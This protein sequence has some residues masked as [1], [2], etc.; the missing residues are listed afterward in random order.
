MAVAST[1]PNF[2]GERTTPRNTTSSRTGRPTYVS[3]NA[4]T[5]VDGGASSLS[6]TYPNRDNRDPPTVTAPDSVLRYPERSV[7]LRTL[8]RV[9]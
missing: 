7:I 1:G 9:G 5:A 6:T 4:D 2:G 3:G 8:S